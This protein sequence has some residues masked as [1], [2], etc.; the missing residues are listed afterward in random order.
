ET[1]PD[2]DWTVE[3]VDVTDNEAK[4]LLMSIDPLAMLAGKD[5]N[6]VRELSAMV[7]TSSAAV[8]QMWSRLSHAEFQPGQ[9]PAMAGGFYVMV[10]CKDEKEQVQILKRLTAEGLRVFA[11]IG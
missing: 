2:E 4:K 8:Q 1:L 10:M 11:K 6:K 5:E 3:V 7:E 9:A